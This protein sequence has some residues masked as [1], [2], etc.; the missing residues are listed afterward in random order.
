MFHLCMLQTGL[1]SLWLYTDT[2]TLQGK[3]EQSCVKS[4]CGPFYNVFF[5]NSRA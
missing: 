5:L 2:I 3:Y 1:L 4:L